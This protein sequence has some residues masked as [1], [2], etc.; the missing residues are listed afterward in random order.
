MDFFICCATQPIIESSSGMKF[1]CYQFFY[2]ELKG[3]NVSLFYLSLNE[4]K[5]ENKAQLYPLTTLAGQ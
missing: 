1:A 2:P 3:E 4:N 5:N